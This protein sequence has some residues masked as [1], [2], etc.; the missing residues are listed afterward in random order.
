MKPPPS[1]SRRV[2][3]WVG[4]VLSAILAVFWL[5]PYVHW[6]SRDSRWLISSHDGYMDIERFTPRFVADLPLRP[7]F[8]TGGF[9]SGGPVLWP[10]VGSN[11]NCTQILIPLWLPLLALAL[12]VAFLWYRDRRPPKGRCQSCGYNLTGNTSGLCPECGTEIGDTRKG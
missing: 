9:S 8:G 4:L 5:G 12:P 2:A 10:F 3:K 7:G 1:R 6:V 11:A